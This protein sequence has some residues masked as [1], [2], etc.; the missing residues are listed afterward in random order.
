LV[1]KLLRFGMQ[2]GKQKSQYDEETING[3]KSQIYIFQLIW[4]IKKSL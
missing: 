4:T 3:W 2:M 1:T